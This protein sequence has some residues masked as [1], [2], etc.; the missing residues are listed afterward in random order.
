[1]SDDLSESQDK[2]QKTGD[3]HVLSAPEIDLAFRLFLNRLP[4]P[5]MRNAMLRNGI[6]VARLRDML[7]KSQEFIDNLSHDADVA[8]AGAARPTLVHIHIPKTAG[9]SLNALLLPLFPRE[10]RVNGHAPACVAALRDMSQSE[11][12]QV[13]L[14]AGHVTHAIGRLFS[15][16]VR[17][18]TIMRDPG[19][20]ILSFFKYVSYREQHPLYEKVHGMD[21][22]TFL[23]FA[24]V[25]PPLL[26]ELEGGQMRR[27]AG[28]LGQKGFGQEP[29]LFEK[30]C[31]NLL[32]PDM[33][34]GFTEAF[35]AFQSRLVAEGILPSARR[36]KQNVSPLGLAY[37]EARENLT[38]DQ[39][40]LLDRFIT[41]DAKLLAF[42]RT[43]DTPNRC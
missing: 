31:Q 21:F 16:P 37:T 7:L 9:T 17:F 39:R 14:V 33:L 23:E 34:F 42:A 11:R 18:L 15:Q 20:R 2:V 30:A 26:S 5:A 8:N 35:D 36:V 4:R 1:M 29:A 3:D 6:T 32:A 27:I 24:V 13:R 22:G 38:S 19:P 43:V 25:T 10:N 41:W 12:E 28:E 40:S